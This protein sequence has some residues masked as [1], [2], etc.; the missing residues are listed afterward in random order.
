M[1]VARLG[2]KFRNFR[3]LKLGKTTLYQLANHQPE[4]E[5]PAIIKELA[6]HATK[7]RLPPRNA[8]RVIEIGIGRH[9]YGD[10]PDATLAALADLDGYKHRDSWHESA[11]AELLRLEPDNEEAA[12]AI[13]SNVSHQDNDGKGEDGAAVGDGDHDQGEG[14]DDDVEAILDSAPPN[15]PPP[16]TSD[17]Q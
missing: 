16:A 1:N 8:E 12:E 2:A 13:I 7:K 9:R 4:D 15:V 5:L 3:N 11:V 6:K 14:S 17:E 10:H